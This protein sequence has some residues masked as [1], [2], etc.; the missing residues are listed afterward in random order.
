MI[1]FI[2]YKGN[3]PKDA[4]PFQNSYLTDEWEG[5][6]EL[7]IWREKEYEVCSASTIKHLKKKK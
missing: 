2:F 5:E 4:L 3:N 6:D 1:S 7:S